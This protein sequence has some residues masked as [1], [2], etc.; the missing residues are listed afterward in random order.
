MGRNRAPRSALLQ[1]EIGGISLVSISSSGIRESASSSD[2]SFAVSGSGL[3][4]FI[5]AFF[6]CCRPPC[7]DD[8]ADAVFIWPCVDHVE[9]YDSIDCRRPESSPSLFVGKWVRD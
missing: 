5:V 4:L 3:P 7:A 8:S 6:M 9:N 1:S 2:F